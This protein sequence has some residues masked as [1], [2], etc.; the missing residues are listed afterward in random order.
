MY[1]RRGRPGSIGIEEEVMK[2]RL[3]LVAASVTLLLS[4]CASVPTGDSPC[5]PPAY[6]G[7]QKTY[8]YHG[9]G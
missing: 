2:Y 1:K 5:Q 6:C 3:S 4:A 8:S 7:S 9:Q